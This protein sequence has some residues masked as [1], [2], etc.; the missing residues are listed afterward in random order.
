MIE[1]STADND[2][3]REVY[4]LLDFVKE[5]FGRTAPHEETVSYVGKDISLNYS[6]ESFPREIMSNPV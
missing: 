2:T 4:N 3:S 1:F 6:I 5:H